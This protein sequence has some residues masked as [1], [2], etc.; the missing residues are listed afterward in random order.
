M[1]TLKAKIN[2]FPHFL[3]PLTNLD[4]KYMG[5]VVWLDENGLVFMLEIQIVDIIT[6]YR[7][8]EDRGPFFYDCT[9]ARLGNRL[10]SP[11]SNLFI[12]H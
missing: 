3:I 2:N 11:E 4:T 5:T 12:E 7:E 9:I 8:M 6:H 10:C 1:E